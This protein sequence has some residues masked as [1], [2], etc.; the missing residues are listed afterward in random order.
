MSI[1]VIFHVKGRVWIGLSDI[2]VIVILTRKKVNIF[3][4]KDF[5]LSLRIVW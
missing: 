4:E 1:P 5:F 3:M 2:D